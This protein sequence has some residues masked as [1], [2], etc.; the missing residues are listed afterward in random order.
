MEDNK[1]IIYTI[2]INDQG[3]IKIDN[4]TKG[5]EKASGAVKKLNQDLLTQ[6]EIMEDN[7]KKNENM[8]DKTGLAGATLVELGRTISD[9]NYGLRAMAN[10]ISQLST[11]FITLITTSGGLTKGFGQLLKVA[12]GP[13]GLIV[14]FQGIIALFERADMQAS[15]LERSTNALT[16]AQAK[17]GVELKMLRKAINDGTFSQEELETVITRVNDE[18]DDLNLR[19]GDNARLTDDSALAI[20]NKI[21]SLEKLAIANAINTEAEKLYSKQLDIDLRKEKALEEARIK[22]GNDRVFRQTSFGTTVARTDE[23][24]EARRQKRIKA[25]EDEFNKEQEKLDEEFKTLRKVADQNDYYTETFVNNSK[26][27]TK[28]TK[29]EEKERLKFAT[30]VE[31]A[32]AISQQQQ[33]E[34]ERQ[35]LSDHYDALIKQTKENGDSTLALE[36]AKFSALNQL[37]NEE[38]ERLQQVQDKKDAIAERETLRDIRIAQ[39]KIRLKQQEL[40][41]EQQID[42]ARVGFA[43]QI[44]GI[45][46]SIAGEGTALAKAGLVI[47]KGA[48]IADIIIKAQQSIATQTAASSAYALQTQAAYAS[49]PVAGVGIAA[50]LIAKNKIALAKNIAQT[51]IGAGLSIA[52]ILATSLASKGSGIQAPSAGTT[53][54]P[55]APQIQAPAFNVVG[56]TQTSQLA[57][58]I[59]GAEDRPVKAF[60]VASDV[61][62]AQ[63][64]ERST[65]EGASLG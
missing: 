28:S 15:K 55:S 39:A 60:V 13:V 18:Y 61:T 19:V 30:D 64:L 49:L 12:M 22:Q 10:N 53:P 43:K 63:E 23:Q 62:T 34:L 21:L 36:I 38:L 33:F 51:K 6:G 56:A 58:T 16:D 40:K 3:K 11:L 26:T 27:R 65:I 45:F 2:E 4:V 44:A 57:Q 42:L 32:L 59:A 20:D 7:A 37:D 25:V 8:I 47:E 52:Q 54:T 50:S 5:F 48:A 31:D 24:T 35:R 46:K 1:R 29:D 9:S 17:A 14:A 41:T